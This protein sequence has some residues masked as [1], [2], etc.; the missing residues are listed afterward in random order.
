MWDVKKFIDSLEISGSTIHEVHSPLFQFQHKCEGFALDFN[1]QKNALLATGCRDHSIHIFT[2]CPTGWETQKPLN[3]HKGSVEGIA[4]KRL[5]N[6]SHLASCSTD[7]S[8]RLH[9][10]TIKSSA[11]VHVGHKKFRFYFFLIQNQIPNAHQDDVNTIAWSPHD[12]H[13][14][15][16]GGDDGV[17]R[18]WDMRN[19]LEPITHLTYHQEPITVTTL[20]YSVFLFLRIVFS[21]FLG[22][23]LIQ[24]HFLL[25]L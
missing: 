18:I 24:L 4:W 9:D 20:C 13:L 14:L 5:G 25:H 22:I 15:L 1:P 21:V 23:R 6:P 11:Q 2:P 3:I 7:R 16:S 8:I 19:V 12:E 10:I 17:I